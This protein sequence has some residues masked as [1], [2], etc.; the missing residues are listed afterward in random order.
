MHIVINAGINRLKTQGQSQHRMSTHS[1]EK[2][3]TG[4]TL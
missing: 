4:E 3:F 2:R 1:L